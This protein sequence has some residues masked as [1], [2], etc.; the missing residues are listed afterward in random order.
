M[1]EYSSDITSTSTLI[2][3]GTTPG[4]EMIEGD[5]DKQPSDSECGSHPF[6]IS[7]FMPDATSIS[8]LNQS[9]SKGMSLTPKTSKKSR[10]SR[11]AMSLLTHP[12]V[13][14][15]P[16]LSIPP[17]IQSSSTI[18]Q[19][20]SALAAAL[21]TFEPS[22]GKKNFPGVPT[23]QVTVGPSPDT[24]LTSKLKGSGKKKTPVATTTKL[25]ILG[26]SPVSLPSTPTVS[27]S[28]K[29]KSSSAPKCVKKTQT[30]S[31]P[32]EPL[33]KSQGDL[34]RELLRQNG[35]PPSPVVDDM[36]SRLETTSTSTPEKGKKSKKKLTPKASPPAP[37][38]VFGTPVSIE[39]TAKKSR[40]RPTKPK[41]RFYCDE[42]DKNYAEK[43]SLKRHKE[44]HHPNSVVQRAAET[45]SIAVENGT[46]MS[47]LLDS[48][49]NFRPDIHRD[50]CITVDMSMI[51]SDTTLPLD[52]SATSDSSVE[53][54]VN[55]V[56]DD[57]EGTTETLEREDMEESL[58]EEEDGEK[59]EVSIPEQ[60]VLI[61]SS[62]STVEEPE[63]RTDLQ[64]RPETPQN[65]QVVKTPVTPLTPFALAFPLPC[66]KSALLQ[67]E[68]ITDMVKEEATK[69]LL[70][71]QKEVQQLKEDDLVTDQAIPEI[72]VN[73]PQPLKSVEDDLLLTPRLVRKENPDDL[74]SYEFVASVK[75]DG[76][77][78]PDDLLSTI[79]D[80]EQC[81]E[82]IKS[83]DIDDELLKILEDDFLP[84]LIYTKW[85]DYDID[86]PKVM[87]MMSPSEVVRHRYEGEVFPHLPVLSHSEVSNFF[88]SL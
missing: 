79:L 85:D 46:S 83:L 6:S 59:V 64:D 71:L 48:S 21:S 56:Y 77:T 58:P 17:V 22:N 67:E 14:G 18:S 52:L 78:G 26:N 87:D 5:N 24:S 35:I 10:G 11:T 82:D 84:Y 32:S 37:P 31:P 66:P 8:L 70:Q 72:D 75:S 57:K 2:S 41:E 49:T 43:R 88:L 40:P 3:N 25:V 33:T 28:T 65:T 45:I 53:H 36:I 44:S 81:E 69:T 27:S 4:L 19:S 51:A 61:P 47:S 15:S 7:I 80:L 60:E 12:V 74:M 63:S 29:R 38:P 68:P 55:D 34:L 76:S 1:H 39:T 23:S 54:E 16:T 50:T 62:A 73:D 20:S 42:C 86:N 9:P 13:D 30:K